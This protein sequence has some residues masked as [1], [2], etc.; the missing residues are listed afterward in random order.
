MAERTEASL[1]G[2]GLVG[3]IRLKISADD[4]PPDFAPDKKFLRLMIYFRGAD[5][6]VSRLEV[7]LSQ[8]TKF[9][10]FSGKDHPQALDA[11]RE[12]IALLGKSTGQALAARL[13][14]QPY[15]NAFRAWQAK[16]G[17]P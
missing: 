17:R 7:V 12:A 16:V 11:A 2:I 1:T 3:T 10:V 15:A 13:L 6:K 4:L 5:E 8:T 9:V 14:L